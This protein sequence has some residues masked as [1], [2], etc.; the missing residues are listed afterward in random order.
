MRILILCLLFH[1]SMVLQGFAQSSN[2]EL[3][4]GFGASV[5]QGDISPTRLGST[6]RPGFSFQ[7][8]GSYVLHPAFSIRGNFAYLSISD[9]EKGYGGYHE[10]RNFKF[11]TTINE[12][13][14]QVVVSPFATYEPTRF[15][16]YVFGGVG[17][18]FLSVNRDWSN[19]DFN[20]PSWQRWVI[21]GLAQDTMT[22]L[23]AAALTFPIGLGLRCKIGENVS[24]Y[25]EGAHR[26]TTNEYID[27]F[28][29]AAN[30]NRNDAFT[31][32]TIGLVFRLG[33]V[34]GGRGGRGGYGCPVN[35]Y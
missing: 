5:Y 4:F 30:P 14:A 11:H 10:H 17:I 28:S 29:K 16:P 9:D 33:E 31:S 22:K 23:P 8:F 6:N 12:L 18:G 3:G 13:S 26:I 32:L 34:T 19:F 2:M 21:P 27:G 15:Q 1:F 7:V 20:F 24:L 35:V 25:A